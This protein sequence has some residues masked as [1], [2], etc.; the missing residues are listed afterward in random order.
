MK[1]GIR[2][3]KPL[4]AAGG[5]IKLIARHFFPTAKGERGKGKGKEGGKRGKKNT[6][7]KTLRWRANEGVRVSFFFFFSPF[8]FLFFFLRALEKERDASSASSGLAEIGALLRVFAETCTFITR[9]IILI[10][11]ELSFFINLDASSL[12]PLRSSPNF[13]IKNGSFVNRD[14]LSLIIYI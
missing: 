11:G 7:Y 12:L 4:L 13:S 10:A 6:D 8:L 2:S 1:V 3:V 14:N 9:L 5:E